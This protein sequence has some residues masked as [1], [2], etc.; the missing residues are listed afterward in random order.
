MRTDRNSESGDPAAAAART[1]RPLMKKRTARRDSHPSRSRDLKLDA[2]R[3][4]G[5]VL[6][7][8]WHYQP[9]HFPSR[10]PQN[11]LSQLPNGVVETF[12]LQVTLIAVPLL[13]LVSLYLLYSN[14]A[15]RPGYIRHRVGR[16]ATLYL[17]WTFVQFLVWI[18]VVVLTSITHS[19]EFALPASGGIR[20]LVMGGPSLPKVGEAVFYYLFDLVILTVLAFAYGKMPERIRLPLAV[21]LTFL[22]VAYFELCSLRSI[23]IPYWR[24]DNFLV[25]VPIAYLLKNNHIL[26]RLRYYLLG[27]FIVFALHDILL[28]HSILLQ[29]P[30]LLQT[31]GRVSVVLGASAAFCI[32][33]SHYTG[34]NSRSVRFLSRHSLG[35]YATHKYM[36]LSWYAFG[37][38]FLGL[39]GVPRIP[40]VVYMHDVGLNI[41]TLVSGLIGAAA[42][43]L[44]VYIVGRTP[45]R[46]FVT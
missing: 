1:G 25:Y 41:W 5:I 21:A 45:L 4:F 32:A 39:F 17:F 10:N 7:V 29:T 19:S 15:E 46:R 18:A 40:D 24:I 3:A 8:I 12:Y 28:T 20:V 11:L 22:S 36:L 35:I 43:L 16:L 13:F 34:A 27:G 26:Y 38:I 14:L 9:L 23:Y 2:L 44:L 30:I 33:Y 37:G 6:V 42:T 31:Y